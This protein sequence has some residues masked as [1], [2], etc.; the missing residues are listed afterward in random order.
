LREAHAKAG[1]REERKDI[2]KG[3]GSGVKKRKRPYII[4]RGRTRKKEKSG[5]E[6]PEPLC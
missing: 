2:R 4:Q 5:A 3:T 6:K 1:K